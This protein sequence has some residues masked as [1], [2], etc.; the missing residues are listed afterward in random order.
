MT[1]E[2]FEAEFVAF[3]DFR[4]QCG[5]RQVTREEFAK[6][7]ERHNAICAITPEDRAAWERMEQEAAEWDLRQLGNLDGPPVDL[8]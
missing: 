7:V 1:S 6:T 8:A 3:N 2:T 5:V 4:R